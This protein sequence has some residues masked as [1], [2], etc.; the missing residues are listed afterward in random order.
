MRRKGKASWD[1]GHWTRVGNGIQVLE[2]NQEIKSSES[3]NAVSI[4]TSALTGLGL[5]QT[6]EFS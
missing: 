3:A 4:S 5:S 6:G 1:S 2:I